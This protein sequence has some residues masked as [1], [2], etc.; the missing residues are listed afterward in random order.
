[1]RGSGSVHA[2]RV[3]ECLCHI[4]TFQGVGEIVGGAPSH[5]A[6]SAGNQ[7]KPFGATLLAE[8][9]ARH[10]VPCMPLNTR[11]HTHNLLIIMGLL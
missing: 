1:V 8:L 4:I 11:R 7:E 5:P 3:P 10:F 6:N 2:D 9:T